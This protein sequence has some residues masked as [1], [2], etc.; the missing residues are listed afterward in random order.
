MARKWWSFCPFERSTDRRT[1]WS[2]RR[3]WQWVKVEYFNSNK[4]KGK[5]KE[6]GWGK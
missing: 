4:G 2:N 5:G 3:G 1:T 6:K